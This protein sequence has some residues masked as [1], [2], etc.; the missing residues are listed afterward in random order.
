MADADELLTSLKKVAALLSGAR[1]RFALAG[2]AATYARGGTLGSHDVDFAVHSEDVEK[3]VVAAAEAGLRVQDPPEDWLVKVYDGDNL[4]DLIYQSHGRRVDDAMLAR[5]DLISVAA[6]AM[7]VLGAGDL[8]VAK[9]LAL[10]AHH[11]DLA[12]PLLTVRVLREQIDWRLVA[13]QTRESPYAQAFLLL[14]RL[15]GIAEPAVP[16]WPWTRV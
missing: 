14:V 10:S 9:L 6:L 3:A 4:I 2:S 15:L 16:E 13:E 1:I 5:C 11:C 8:V 12:E 7:P